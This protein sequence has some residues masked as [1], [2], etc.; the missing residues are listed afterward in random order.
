MK[1]DLLG[2][3][4]EVT[5]IKTEVTEIKDTQATM[6]QR[7]TALENQKLK[8]ERWDEDG[9]STAPTQAYSQ[10]APE[11]QPKFI[12]IRGWCSYDRRTQEGLTRKEAEELLEGLKELLDEGIREHVREL[13]PQSARSFSL[14][15]YCTTSYIREIK[16]S[17]VDLLQDKKIKI[18]G[19]PTEIRVRLEASPQL[20]A[21]WRLMGQAMEWSKKNINETYRP[22]DNWKAELT[23]TV[24]LTGLNGSYSVNIL[25]VNDHTEIE[26]AQQR[27]TL[28]TIGILNKDEAEAEIRRTKRS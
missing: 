15:V 3:K 14:H 6:E 20:Q 11:F 18:R 16:N 5:E 19:E 4:A 7:L 22:T 8:R 17:W 2:M 25:T 23:I 12:D 28:T 13:R 10:T 27:E 9:T 21:K 26:W 1:R 24:T